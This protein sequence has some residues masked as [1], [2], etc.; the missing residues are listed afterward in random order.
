MPR[1]DAKP[2]YLTLQDCEALRHAIQA[3]MGLISIVPMNGGSYSD[4]D[5]ERLKRE[6]RSMKRILKYLERRLANGE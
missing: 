1:V 5:R 3:R 2:L 6:I 4:H